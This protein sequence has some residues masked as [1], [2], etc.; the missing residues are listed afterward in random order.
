MY[1]VCVCACVMTCLEA[2][3]HLQSQFYPSSF[4]VGLEFRLPFLHDKVHYMMSSLAG[5]LDFFFFTSVGESIQGLVHDRQAIH[6]LTYIPSSLLP[7]FMYL[8]VSFQVWQM[9][10]FS[11]SVCCPVLTEVCADIIPPVESPEAF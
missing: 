1:M 5:H 9:C 3:G 2:R 6:Q 11:Y 7:Y 8:Q 4:C 10:D